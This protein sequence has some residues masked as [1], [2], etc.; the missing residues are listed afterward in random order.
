MLLPFPVVIFS[1]YFSCEL[2]KQVSSL[3]H[4]GGTFPYKELLQAAECLVKIR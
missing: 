4:L 3:Q 2:Y 1:Q